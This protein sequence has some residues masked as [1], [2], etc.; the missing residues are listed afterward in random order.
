MSCFRL[1]S[2]SPMNGSGEHQP[3]TIPNMAVQNIIHVQNL[4]FSTD[5]PEKLADLLEAAMRTQNITR[6]Q[7]YLEVLR[8]SLVGL[9][10]SQPKSMEEALWTGFFFLKLPKVLSIM[11]TRYQSSSS[12]SMEHTLMQATL[13]QL[14]VF[15]PLLDDVDVKY[16]CNSYKEFIQQYSKHVP[17]QVADRLANISLSRTIQNEM[18]IAMNTSGQVHQPLRLLLD[19]ESK[20]LPILQLLEAND[21]TRDD[22]FLNQLSSLFNVAHSRWKL[23][24]VASLS[25]MKNLVSDLISRGNGPF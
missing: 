21:T 2:L 5:I 12:T 15:S 10:D 20:V 14:R 6:P 23:V 9:L 7:L 24:A 3:G 19:A 22:R 18:Q 17:Q 11:E 13:Q 16:R 4:K 1:H 8:S 25:K